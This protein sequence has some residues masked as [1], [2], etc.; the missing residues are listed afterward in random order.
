MSDKYTAEYWQEMADE[1]MDEFDF[2]KVHRCMVALNW[3]WHDCAGVPEKSELRRAC[4]GWLRNAIAGR[5]GAS[6]GFSV[7]I[8]REEGSLTLQFIVE[9]WDAYKEDV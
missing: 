8:D 6:G 5:A 3:T 2:D 9:A 4:R 1:I 7:R